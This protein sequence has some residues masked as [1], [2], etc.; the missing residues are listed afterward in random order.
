MYRN[1]FSFRNRNIAKEMVKR[2]EMYGYKALVLTV[3]TPLLGTRRADVRNRYRLPP[4]L[5]SV[6][7]SWVH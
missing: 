5:R 2:A 1:F 6:P 7:V 3:D 4:H